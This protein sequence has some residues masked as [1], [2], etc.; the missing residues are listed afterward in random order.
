MEDNGVDYESRKDLITDA[1]NLIPGFT[2]ANDEVEFFLHSPHGHRIN[3]REIEDRNQDCVVTQAVFSSAGVETKVILAG[4]AP[5]ECLQDIVNITKF[6]EREHRLDYDVFKLPHHSS[7]LSL[8]DDKGTTQTVPKNEIKEWYD[9]GGKYCLLVSS[10]EIIGT[11]D[12]KM[13][14]HFQAAN[15]YRSVASAK[16][17]QFKVTMEHPNGFNPQPIVVEIDNFGSTVKGVATVIGA[18]QAYGSTPPKAG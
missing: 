16:Q 10:S 3:E 12:Q 7:Y 13:P 8:S 1:G 6:H 14:P 17:G 2:L 9:R 11:A 5:W 4:D 18:S 15:Y